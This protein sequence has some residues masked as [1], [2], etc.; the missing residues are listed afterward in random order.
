M[1]TAMPRKVI[2]LPTLIIP[3]LL[4]SNQPMSSQFYTYN[5]Q[6]SQITSES[7]LIK[8][9]Y[10]NCSNPFPMRSFGTRRRF[11]IFRQIESFIVHLIHKSLINTT[12]LCY[13]MCAPLVLLSHIQQVV[14]QPV[15]LSSLLSGQSRI[16]TQSLESFQLLQ[17]S[18]S[19]RL[20]SIL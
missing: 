2:S 4:V 14:I 17:S 13:Y 5:M 20:K 6:L 1:N 16:T 9:I 10:F 8:Q 15:T 11:S 7:V 3:A 18:T 19:I 12:L